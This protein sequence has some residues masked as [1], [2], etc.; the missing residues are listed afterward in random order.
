MDVTSTLG[1]RSMTFTL[2]V[3]FAQSFL[4]VFARIGV[5]FM[6]M[7]MIG[8]RFV[9]PRIRLVF[10]LF[11]SLLLL[12]PLRTDLVRAARGGDAIIGAFL[13]EILIGLS[14]GLIVRMLMMAAEMGSQFLTQA[15]GLSL[16]ETLNPTYEGQSP[17]L[18]SFLT[19]LFVTFLFVSDAHHVLISAVAAT[20]RSLP[21][22]GAF[23]A[24]DMVSLA[25]SSAGKEVAL[26]MRIAAPFLLFSIVLNTAL[27]IISRLMPQIQVTF[28][29]VPISILAGLLLMVV[30]L[31]G[32]IGRLA[33]DFEALLSL[34]SGG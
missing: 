21:P 2:P 14:L 15:L 27:G 24:D 33:V 17:V 3:E 23:A 16:G 9:P 8:E 4:L 31:E 13:V 34:I 32:L 30:L 6:L 28:V 18:G 5:L 26:A 20:Y 29:A 10:A 12:P 19:L 25:L 22:G 11:M 7:P 1:R